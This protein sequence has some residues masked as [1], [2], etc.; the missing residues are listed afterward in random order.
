MI[1]IGLTGK[2]RSGKDTVAK[3]LGMNYGFT[4]IAFADPLK[5]A[6]QQMFGLTEE[7]TWSD[8]LKEVVIERWGK[9]PRQILQL[10]GTEAAHPIFGKDIWVKRFDMSYELVKNVGHVVATDARTDT[11]A[12]Y[13]R[14]NGGYVVEIQR[15]TGLSGS[16]GD[17]ASERG[18]S[19]LP[20]FVIDNTGSLD[21][22]F[23]R[24]EQIYGE[25]SK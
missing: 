8:G 12:D 14:A 17:H 5:L 4:R 19:T 21:D 6:A 13:I 2:A 1:L 3:I 18:L 22:L 7:Q 9:S 25:V 16:V 23:K 20:D 11:E 24:V 15:G 10:L